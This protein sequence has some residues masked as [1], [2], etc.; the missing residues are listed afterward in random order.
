[1]GA[2]FR[3]GSKSQDNYAE[4]KFAPHSEQ[5]ISE[6]RDI[7][8]EI[9]YPGEKLIGNDYW[10]S[11]ILS[12]HNSISQAYNKKDRLYPELKPQFDRSPGS[13]RSVSLR[14]GPHRRMVPFHH[15]AGI[16][17]G[18]RHPGSAHSE[19]TGRNEHLES[20]YLPSVR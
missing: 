3:I 10:V 1:M 15:G 2:L 20:R 17:C 16:L 13:R 7:L 12:H 4:N 5:Q 9:G 19:R 11:T 14:V 8:L 18:I 6:L